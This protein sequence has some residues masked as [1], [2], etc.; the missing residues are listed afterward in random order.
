LE[1][2]LSLIRIF[3]YLDSDSDSDSDAD[4]TPKKSEI[5]PLVDLLVIEERRCMEKLLC[6]EVE[7][8]AGQLWISR[9]AFVHSC[10]DQEKERLRREWKANC[11]KRMDSN[12]RAM[13][14]RME[15]AKMEALE[16]AGKSTDHDNDDDFSKNWRSSH[17]DIRE[18]WQS[19]MAI[20]HPRR[21]QYRRPYWSVSNKI[22]A[23]PPRTS[24]TVF[25][26]TLHIQKVDCEDRYKR[27]NVGC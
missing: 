18:A 8:W 22:S 16:N 20:Q 24:K 6:Y 27:Q 4:A 25:I 2:G 9:K 5:H 19:F 1:A 17:D 15:A 3:L 23:T 12:I 13:D 10:Q 26:T 11:W 14:A 7:A 21:T